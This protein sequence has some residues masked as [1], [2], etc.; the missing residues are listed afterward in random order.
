VAIEGRSRVPNLDVERVVV[1]VDWQTRQP[2]YLFTRGA[3]GRLLE[4]GIPVHRFS[5]DTLN[6][7]GWENGEPASVFDPVAEAFYRVVDDSGWLRE[8]FDVRSIPTDEEVRRRFTSTDFL[9][10]GR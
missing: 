2:L 10:R 5:D 9:V 8:S 3:M 6:Y 7:P 4:V 1:Y